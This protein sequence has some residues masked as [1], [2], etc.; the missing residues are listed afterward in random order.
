MQQ[1]KNIHSQANN[2]ARF[3]NSQAD[4]AQ[5]PNAMR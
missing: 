3:A 5:S 1:L 4:N 2:L